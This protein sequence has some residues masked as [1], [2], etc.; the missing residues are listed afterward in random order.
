MTPVI[1]TNV[2][3]KKR[4]TTANSVQGTLIAARKST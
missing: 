3:T 1:K 4:K 2:G